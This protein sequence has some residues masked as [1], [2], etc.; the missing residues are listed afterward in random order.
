ME[1]GDVLFSMPLAQTWFARTQYNAKDD[2]KAL[3][4]EWG[5]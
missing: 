5:D 1:H 4:D 2:K 3:C